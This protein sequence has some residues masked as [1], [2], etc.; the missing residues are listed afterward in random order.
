MAQVEPQWE[1]IKEAQDMIVKLC[2]TYPDRIGH[3]DP[4]Q[5]GCAAITN[6]P[7]PDSQDFDSK[8][9]G[10]KKPEALF[11]TKAYVICFYKNV[12]DS[13]TQAQRSVMLM[14]NLLRIP[15]EMD[16]S[17]LKEDLKDQKCLV[18][19]WGVDYVNNPALPDLTEK[20][21]DF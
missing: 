18:V 13:Y 12:W 1:M 10:I 3:V 2:D 7:K 5:I 20:R 6:K 9:Q 15:E 19:K 4:N 11:A 21:H 17:L 16:G 14:R 8:I